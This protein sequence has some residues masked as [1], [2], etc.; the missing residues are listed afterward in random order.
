MTKKDIDKKNGLP[1]FE[2]QI[3]NSHPQNIFVIV[4]TEEKKEIYGI[5]NNIGLTEGE[6]YG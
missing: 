1:V 2:V 4:A 6:D 5:L 3:L